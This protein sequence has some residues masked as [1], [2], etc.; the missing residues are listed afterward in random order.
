MISIERHGMFGY[1]RFA[2]G[3]AVGLGLTCSVANSQSSADALNAARECS[4]IANDTERL[5]CLDAALGTRDASD[6]RAAP[7]AGSDADLAEARAAQ[8]S[9]V[10]SE[11]AEI[12]P[13]AAEP[14]GAEPPVVVDT[15]EA[16]AAPNGVE[17][18]PAREMSRRER[19]RAAGEEAERTI[20]IVEIRRSGVGVLTFIAEDGEA[21]VERSASSVRFPQVPFDAVLRPALG[22]SFFLISAVSSSRARVVPAR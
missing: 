6:E 7:S 8:P 18:P 4:R 21:W 15:V 14:I 16:D 12:A 17:A 2:V 1:V 19:R 10:E 20:R 3:A 13:A 22:D 9:P 5:A 11:A